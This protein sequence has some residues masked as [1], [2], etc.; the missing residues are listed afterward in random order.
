[1][2]VKTRAV[3]AAATYKTGLV[4]AELKVDLLLHINIVVAGARSGQRKEE[5]IRGF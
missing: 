1:M 4:C 5:R 3:S 2:R